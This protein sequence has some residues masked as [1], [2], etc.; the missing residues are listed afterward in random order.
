MRNSSRKPNCQ[1]AKYQRFKQFS[2]SRVFLSKYIL[3]TLVVVYLVA[4]TTADAW[5]IKQSNKN[6]SRSRFLKLRSVINRRTRNCG[7]KMRAKCHKLGPVCV[8]HV[9]SKRSIDEEETPKYLAKRSINY[10]VRK[11]GRRGRKFRGHRQR[12]RFKVTCKMCE[13]VCW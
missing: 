6:I 9:L 3:L 1:F 13:S 2:S 7:K 11:R 12:Y 5:K 4:L 10:R 8:N